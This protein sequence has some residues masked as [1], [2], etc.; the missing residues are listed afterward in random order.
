MVLLIV[1]HFWWGSGVVWA[2]FCRFFIGG[3]ERV[4]EDQVYVPG[5]WELQLRV[6]GGSIKDFERTKPSQSQ[7][8]L[9]VCGFNV[10][11]F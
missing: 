9:G 3:N 10:G 8:S 6:S 2:V 11:T 7:L 4:V 1:Y 5:R